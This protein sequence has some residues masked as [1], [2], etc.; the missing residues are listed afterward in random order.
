M[1]SHKRLADAKAK[2]DGLLTIA[3]SGY[4]GSFSRYRQQ[5]ADAK[6][7]LFKA[8]VAM[9]DSQIAEFTRIKAGIIRE[10]E[11][12]MEVYNAVTN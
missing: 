7:E 2:L 4:A 5:I 8:R 9:L 10:R 11:K 6:E 12:E 1:N 3:N